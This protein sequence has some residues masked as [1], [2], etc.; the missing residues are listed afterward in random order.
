MNDEWAPILITLQRILQSMSEAKFQICYS[1]DWIALDKK[2]FYAQP[3]FCRTPLSFLE[4]M[5]LEFCW[6]NL[7]LSQMYGYFLIAWTMYFDLICY[8]EGWWI[9]IQNCDIT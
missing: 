1:L 3:V 8:Y 5:A 2:A 6:L 4:G 9:S 7:S